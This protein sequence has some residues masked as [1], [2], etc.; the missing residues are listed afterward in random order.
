MGIVQERFD[1]AQ[2][3]ASPDRLEKYSPNDTH[4]EKADFKTLAERLEM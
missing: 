4:S 2:V 1:H 3:M